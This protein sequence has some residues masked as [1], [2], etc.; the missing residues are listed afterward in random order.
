MPTGPNRD[1]YGAGLVFALNDKSSISM[2]YTQR[3]VERTRLTLLDQNTR[4]IV[5]SQANVALVNLGATF[6][7]GKNVALVTNFGMGLTDASPDMAISVR[8]PYRF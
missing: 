2:S 6:P 8:V 7:L 1:T 3:I 5:G 4:S